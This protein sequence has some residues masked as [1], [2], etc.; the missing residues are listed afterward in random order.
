MDGRLAKFGQ[1]GQRKWQE[2]LPFHRIQVPDD[3][4]DA[5]PLE[6]QK[7]MVPILRYWRCAGRSGGSAIYL[8]VLLVSHVLRA[9]LCF[10]IRSNLDTPSVSKNQIPSRCL[11]RCDGAVVTA[12]VSQ[13]VSARIGAHQLGLPAT[14]FEE[15]LRLHN[16]R[17]LLSIL[18]TKD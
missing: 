15:E 12:E 11:H 3:V 13:Y 1:D 2:V 5:K 7:S 6:G 4:L 14:K 16:G 10:G 17:S 18:S 8:V 9:C